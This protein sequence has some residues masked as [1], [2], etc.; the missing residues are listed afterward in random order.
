MA[1]SSVLSWEGPCLYCLFHVPRVQ[2]FERGEKK[3]A[4]AFHCIHVGTEEGATCMTVLF[5]RT[6]LGTLFPLL[7]LSEA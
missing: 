2:T 5:L 4:A 1:H 7:L 6:P 3:Q